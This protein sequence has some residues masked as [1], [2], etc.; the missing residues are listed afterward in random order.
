[1]S[2]S[3]GRGL[4]A[5]RAVSDVI[6][7]DGLAQHPVSGVSP[8]TST[9]RLTPL[10]LIAAQP[11]IAREQ[12]LSILP[13]ALWSYIFMGEGWEGFGRWTVS[14]RWAFSSGPPKR[15]ASPTLAGA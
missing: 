6:W 5:S 2:L 1:M 4:T 13:S 15:E 3:V 9:M 14:P 11:E 7:P 10:M 12:Q 8:S